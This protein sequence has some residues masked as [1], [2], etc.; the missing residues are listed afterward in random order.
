MSLLFKNS[1][2][3]I[4]SSF[5][6]YNNIIKSENN[7]K[8]NCHSNNQNFA[9]NNNLFNKIS[10]LDENNENNL[11]R[12]FS[13][14]DF[15]FNNNDNNR[16]EKNK[17][18]CKMGRNCPYLKRYIILK[19]EI[20]GLITSINKIK[21]IN[22]LLSQSL[23]KKSKL[24]QI[25]IGENENL[26]KEYYK[27]NQKIYY[28]DFYKNEKLVNL[29]LHLKLNKKNESFK[30][31]K[32]SIINLNLKN[33]SY[34][35]KNK[36]IKNNILNSIFFDRNE[37]KNNIF[38]N[39]EINSQN[40]INYSLKSPK[41][42]EID[43]KD[44]N[45]FNNNILNKISSIQNIRNNDLINSNIPEIHY[46][47][48]NKYTK[49][50][51]SK[52]ISDKMKR[53][54]LSYKADYEALIK[55]NN[56]LNKLIHL[57]KSEEKFISIINSSSDDI[58]LKYFD[59]INLLINDYKDMLKLGI[60]MKDFI[61]NSITLVESIIDNKSINVLIENTCTVLN[62]DR[63]SLFI[64]D[65]ISDSLIVHSGEGVRKAQIKVPKDKGI[66]GTCFMN[67]QKIRIDDAYLDVRFNKEIDKLTNYRTRSILC[68]PLVDNHGECFG[69]IEAINKMEPPFN[70]D[71]EEL[72]KLLAQQASI[73]FRSL[74]SIDDNRNLT[75]KLLKIVNYNINIYN[76]NGKFEFT[77]KTE[78][79]LLNIFD[80]MDSRFYFVEKNKIIRYKKNE[81]IEYDNNTGIIGKV[82]RLKDIL[83]YQNI[84]NS[85]D[86][87][88]IIDINSY[89]GILTFPILEIKTK[90]IKAVAQ[91]PYIGKIYKNGK[92]KDSDMNLIK[93]LRK[94]IKFWI[95]KNGY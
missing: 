90:F 37:S 6:E 10:F 50:Q 48:I 86:Y 91:I 57:T 3:P 65:K 63:A 72:I 64:L 29:Q 46:D 69:V 39:I 94:C 43:L 18:I 44:L 62:C 1:L 55:N 54:F 49:S 89:D 41:K 17:N 19:R 40:I 61:K 47:L 14:N 31:K 20:K 79:V 59:I 45:K 30:N 33:N 22:E 28:N 12:S 82:I 52:F 16:K 95:K 60:R 88:S 27:S 7:K 75:I 87:N 92:P 56:A 35:N 9:S 24:Y 13:N 32:K 71:D 85:V 23:D 78:D 11:V 25:L 5:D 26:K 77:E 42:Q 80:C 21:K 93:I 58:L 8:N 51:K 73:I 34:K 53:S 15:Y 81:R 83:G 38:Q 4:E 76:I 74:N 67:M 66:V 84:K 36:E 68:Y 70:I 2:S